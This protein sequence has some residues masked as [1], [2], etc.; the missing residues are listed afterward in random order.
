MA[1]EL[2]EGIVGADLDRIDYPEIN[3]CITI[4]AIK[5]KG[6]I[7]GHF[8]M[9]VRGMQSRYPAPDAIWRK[10]DLENRL[11]RFGRVTAVYALGCINLWKADATEYT[12]PQL[13]KRDIVKLFGAGINLYSWDSQPQGTVLIRVTRGLGGTGAI[14]YGAQ[15]AGVVA[16]MQNL[17]ANG[18]TLETDLGDY[19][20]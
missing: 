2:T 7:G 18:L 15:N 3:T 9:P 5:G 4:T 17:V 14:S 11:Q 13:F 20:I 1:R 10:L 16:A 19:V 8:S 6:I 12:W